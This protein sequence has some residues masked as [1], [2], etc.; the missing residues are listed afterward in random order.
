[1][2]H[3]VSTFLKKLEEKKYTCLL[4]E[5]Y[6]LKKYLT[7]TLISAFLRLKLVILTDCFCGFGA[8]NLYSAATDIGY[9]VLG[10]VE[11]YKKNSFKLY[12]AKF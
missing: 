4:Y 5:P 8:K 6:V 1:M 3:Y 10:L 9:Y 2:Y 11:K 7:W 12:S